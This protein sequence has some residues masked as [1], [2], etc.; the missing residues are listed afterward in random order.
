MYGCMVVFIVLFP[1]PEVKSIPVGVHSPSQMHGLR[2]KLV[3]LGQLYSR[4][5][6]Y[7]PL[8]YLVQ[9]LEQTGCRHDWDAAFVHQTLLEIGVAMTTLF[10]IYDR[11]FKAKVE[12]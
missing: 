9:L 8:A 12:N 10:T 1:L 4:S 7:F 3:E 6:R 5:E 2:T 11:L